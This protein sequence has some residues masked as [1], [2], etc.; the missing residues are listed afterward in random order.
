MN[1]HRE[2]VPFYSLRR[3]P[4][5][6]AGPF[7]NFRICPRTWPRSCLQ[8]GRKQIRQPCDPPRRVP[9]RSRPSVR[10][11][12]LTT[13]RPISTFMQT[14]YP[15]SSPYASLPP[16][17]AAGRLSP[18]ASSRRRPRG[19][20]P[21]PHMSPCSVVATGANASPL[22]PNL[23]AS[24]TPASA[25]ILDRHHRAAWCLQVPHG[26]TARPSRLFRASVDLSSF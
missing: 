13:A 2:R 6:C 3:P 24:F 20:P 26:R 11:L 23:I 21:A 8:A 15:R 5:S 22:A 17:P 25:C 16:G 9:M 14:T 10:I 4:V 1:A 19:R 7:F 18:P 12:Y